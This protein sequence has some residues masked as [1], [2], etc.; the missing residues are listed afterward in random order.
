M[1]VKVRFVVRTFP[2]LPFNFQF[3]ISSYKVASGGGGD[4]SGLP[5]IITL[6]MDVYKLEG[7]MPLFACTNST[8]DDDDDAMC[9]FYIQRV[10]AIVL[11]NVNVYTRSV[12][13]DLG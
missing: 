11:D 6:L 7:L 9:F 5:Y 3:Y 10:A 13:I 2:F 12:V 1:A 4:G 8:T